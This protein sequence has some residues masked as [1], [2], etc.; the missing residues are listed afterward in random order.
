A[1]DDAINEGRYRDADS[2]ENQI[3]RIHDM[4]IIDALSKYCVIPKYGFPVDVVDLKLYVNGV[5]DNRY[6]LNRDLRIAISEYAPDS[7]VIVNKK[8]YTSKYITLPKVGEL[9]KRYFCCCPTCKKIN[10]TIDK[11]IANYCECG[12]DL[13]GERIESFI[14]PS[15]GFKTGI[16]KESTRMKPKR[17][18]SGE[19]SYIGKG[20]KDDEEILIP[21]RLIIESFS[22]DHLLVLNKS[23]FYTCPVC[24]YSEKSTNN[25]T[26]TKSAKHKNYRQYDCSCDEL[27]LTRIGHVFQTDVVKLEIPSLGI[28]DKNGFAKALSFMYA[29]LEGISIAMNIE[30]ED[31]DG[32]V[33]WNYEFESYDIL[34]F[35]NVPGGAGHVKRLMGKQKIIK[36]LQIA[37][38]KVSKSCC[39]EDT[40]CYNCLRNYYN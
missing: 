19:I 39:D 8:K 37:L 30:R 26:L 22:N 17:S 25:L 29:L 24:G 6:D 15:L 40:S 12:E 14:E 10:L 35:D 32:V 5:I 21:N 28:N 7:E 33:K 23:N 3:K 16:T 34:L 27:N 4:K 9:E 11:K 2:I 13:S 18:Y 31:I 36:S 38:N 20:I 1:K